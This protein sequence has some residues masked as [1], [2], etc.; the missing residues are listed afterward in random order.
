MIGFLRGPS[1]LSHVI[2]LGLIL[3]IV[4]PLLAQWLNSISLAF[5]LGVTLAFCYGIFA[6][7]LAA[8]SR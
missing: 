2:M 4:V 1:L 3:A 6:I 8:R 5:G 7:I